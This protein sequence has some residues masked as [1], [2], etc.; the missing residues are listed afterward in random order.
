MSTNPT[1][2]YEMMI[3]ETHLDVMRHVNNARYLEILEQARWDILEKNGFGLD[4]II[5]KEI[6]PVILEIQLQ[7]LKELKHREKIVIE[8]ICHPMTGKVG[9]I[10]QT[11]FK[12]NGEKACYAKMKFGQFDLK[13]RKLIEPTPEFLKS[14][15]Y[16]SPN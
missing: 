15:G 12:S 6:G 2:R 16:T 7:F 9:L 1:F 3:Q 14:L 4:V 11:I 8:S 10:E 13:K 5:E